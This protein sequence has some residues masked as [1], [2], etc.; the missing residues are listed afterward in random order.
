MEHIGTDLGS[1]FDPLLGAFD[2]RLLGIAAL[3]LE[4]VQAGLEQQQ[5]LGPVLRLVAGL[6]VLDED[7][8]IL[9]CIRI[10]VDVAQ[11]DP[12]LDLVDIL[13]SVTSRAECVPR[14]L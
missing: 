12:G 11:T 13:A 4:I 2:L 3:H 14:K 6:G 1:P 7:L 10:C 9:S 8:L 5:S